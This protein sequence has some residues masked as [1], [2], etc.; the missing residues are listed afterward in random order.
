MLNNDCFAEGIVIRPLEEIED[1][2]FSN[3]INYNRISFK[4]INPE[5]L[6]KNDD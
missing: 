3:I 2:E 5:Y 4:V 6:I 1:K